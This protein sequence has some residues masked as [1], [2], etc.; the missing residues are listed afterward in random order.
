[1]ER[2]YT[3]FN[4]DEEDFSNQLGLRDDDTPL[5]DFTS[6]DDIRFIFE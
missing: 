4:Q 3:A 6:G 5:Y 2:F 1:M